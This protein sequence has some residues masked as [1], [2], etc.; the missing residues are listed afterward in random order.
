MLFFLHLKI[1]I[2]Q[3]FHKN[4]KQRNCF[5]G[6]W[7]LYS[8]LCCKTLDAGVY[9]KMDDTHYTQFTVFELEPVMAALLFND[10]FK[11]SP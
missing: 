7:F 11:I 3:V 9:V 5:L 1:N 8:E 10:F 4:I 2:F 6:E